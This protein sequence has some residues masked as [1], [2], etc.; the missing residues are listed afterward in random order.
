MLIIMDFLIL[1]DPND[2]GE[3]ITYLHKT[4]KIKAYLN[5]EISVLKKRHVLDRLLDIDIFRDIEGQGV[6]NIKD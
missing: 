4:F 6:S 5:K 2:T 3:Y 1:K